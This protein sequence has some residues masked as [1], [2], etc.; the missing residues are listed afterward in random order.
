MFYEK[1]IYIS[2]EYCDTAVKLG[3][4]RFFYLLQNAMI[5]GFDM[6][7]CGN[8]GLKE[9]CNGYWA[10]TKTKLDIYEQPFYSDVV[11][12]KADYSDDGRLRV[13]VNTEILS[14]SGKLLAKGCQELCVLDADTHRPK[15]LTDTPIALKNELVKFLEFEKFS[16]SGELSNEYEITVR[17]QHIDMSKHVNNIEYIR[18]ATDLF[19]VLE[20]EKRFIGGMEIHYLSECREGDRLK[21]IRTDT[22]N[23]SLV[24]IINGE[25]NAAEIMFYFK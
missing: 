12:V 16:L 9:K 8:R 5:D 17:S 10:V 15:R 13:Y 7:N 22:E 18:M 11:K 19:S 6:R 14:Q 24:K 4:Y 3:N 1:D 25:K 20:L 21:C 2:A 23:K